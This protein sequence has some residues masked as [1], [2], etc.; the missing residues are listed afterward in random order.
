M[1]FEVEAEVGSRGVSW[2]VGEV[3]ATV[4]VCG[5]DGVA[6]RRRLACGRVMLQLKNC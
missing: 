5:P 3:G 2:V 6:M 1:R 4:G